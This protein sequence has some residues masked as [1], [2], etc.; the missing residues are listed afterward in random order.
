MAGADS[1]LAV[2]QRAPSPS[3]VG[4]LNSDI[5]P[6]RLFGRTPQLRIRKAPS[7][8]ICPELNNKG[9]KKDLMNILPQ[10]NG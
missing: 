8:A 4:I 7:S 2:R 10:Y 3:A 6:Q 9:V 5:H 1:A